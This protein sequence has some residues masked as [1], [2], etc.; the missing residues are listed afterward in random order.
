MSLSWWHSEKENRPG[1]RTFRQ[2]GQNTQN[3]QVNDFSPYIITPPWSC[4]VLV[5]F[6]LVWLGLVWFDLVFWDCLLPVLLSW[7]LLCRPSFPRTPEIPLPPPEIQGLCPADLAAFQERS[8]H[9][10]RLFYKLGQREHI[11]SPA[12]CP[13][14]FAVFWDRCSFLP[15]QGASSWRCM[16]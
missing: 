15:Y 14:T 11:K 3:T 8:S 7:S 12:L 5:S 13:D 6:G 1:L 10:S 2:Q 16:P 9:S 4:L